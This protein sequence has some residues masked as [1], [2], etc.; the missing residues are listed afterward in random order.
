MQNEKISLIG[1]EKIFYHPRILENIVKGE[2]CFPVHMHLGLVNYCNHHCIFCYAQRQQ[3]RKQQ[4]CRERLLEI[5]TEMR[6][7]GL[8]AVTVCGSGEPTLHPNFYNIIDDMHSL[9]LEI[10]LFTNGSLLTSKMTAMLA[11]VATFVRFSFTGGTPAIYNAVHRSSE[12][13]KVTENLRKLIQSRGTNLFPSIGIQFVLTSYSQEGILLAAA[14][15]KELGADYFAIKPCLD[16]PQN[17]INTKNTISMQ[18]VNDLICEIKLME[19]S[20]FII[21]AKKSQHENILI[22]QGKKNYT[23]CWGGGAFRVIMEQDFKLYHCPFYMNNEDCLGDLTYEN[24]SNVWLSQKHKDFINNIDLHKCTSGCAY[25]EHN[26]L[27][28]KIVRNKKMI[29]RNLTHDP[30]CHPNFV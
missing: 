1:P 25:N 13:I 16:P 28:E 4:I 29:I 5:I 11:A 17:N 20:N 8:K 12:F 3:T 2:D 30:F 10:G 14:Q 21:F 23:R 27:I 15:A 26:K 9:G 6:T 19:D 24:F 7:L 18:R 22:E